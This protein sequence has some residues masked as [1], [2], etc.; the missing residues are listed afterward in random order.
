MDFKILQIHSFGIMIRFRFS[1]S[2]VSVIPNLISDRENQT[3]IIEKIVFY[4]LILFATVFKSRI[5]LLSYVTLL[6][7]CRKSLFFS[8]DS[9]ELSSYYMNCHL[10]TLV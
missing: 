6:A 9:K 10:G 5:Y 1:H 7:F 4:H 2:A 8:A 3:S